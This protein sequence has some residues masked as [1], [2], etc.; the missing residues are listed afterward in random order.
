MVSLHP[1]LF[2]P[3]VG[4]VLFYYFTD[5][6]FFQNFHQQKRTGDLHEIG[7]D[8]HGGQHRQAFVLE[9]QGDGHA[10]SQRDVAQIAPHTKARPTSLLWKVR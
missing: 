7:Q 4:T 8:N 6:I 1:A 3:R 2:S 10:Q 9:H 5:L